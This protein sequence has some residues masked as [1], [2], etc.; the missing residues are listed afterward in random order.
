[1]RFTLR[2]CRVCGS[3]GGSA[4]LT[5]YVQSKMTTKM[6]Q[7]IHFIRDRSISER[8]AGKK[9]RKRREAPVQKDGKK[10]KKKKRTKGIRKRRNV[11]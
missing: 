2:T 1:M 3:K 7:A 5:K 6:K 11:Q 4:K 9:K 10:K 8:G